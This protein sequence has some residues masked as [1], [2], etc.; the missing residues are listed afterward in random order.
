MPNS[1]VLFLLL[2]S[3][4]SSSSAW[5]EMDHLSPEEIEWV[6][7]IR[8]VY[9]SWDSNVG[10]LNKNQVLRQARV[11]AP[12]NIVVKIEV[13]QEDQGLTKGSLF[14]DNVKALNITVKSNP[15]VFLNLI[16]FEDE[17]AW[18]K[19]KLE[20]LISTASANSVNIVLFGNEHFYFKHQKYRGNGESWRGATSAEHMFNI[21]K[22]FYIDEMGLQEGSTLAFALDQKF[23]G[24]SIDNARCFYDLSVSMFQM[25]EEP[26]TGSFDSWLTYFSLN[27][28]E[29][30][31]YRAQSARDSQEFLLQEGFAS[32]NRYV[33]FA[34]GLIEFHFNVKDDIPFS[35]PKVLDD[36][37]FRLEE[38]GIDLKDSVGPQDSPLAIA[39]AEGASQVYE[40][41]KGKY[42][43]NLRR[44]CDYSEFANMEKEEL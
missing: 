6:K 18:L 14:P 33:F 34:E 15:G 37:S 4:S 29:I 25:N 24:A 40:S 10:D 36:F 28:V 21:F 13:P 42:K 12:E 16:A 8:K 3:L 41:E 19:D 23:V 38:L 31:R 32:F 17:V 2:L 11:V 26:D 44:F 35:E 30:D 20:A 1:L 39:F 7:N 43:F 9:K 27:E 22:P 5:Y